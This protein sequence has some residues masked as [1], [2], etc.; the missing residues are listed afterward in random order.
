MH[1]CN[2]TEFL[3]AALEN[4]E[5]W[6]FLVG[7]HLEFEN[8]GECVIREVSLQDKLIVL[9]PVGN[10]HLTKKMRL[11]RFNNFYFRP[12]FVEESVYEKI[13][14]ALQDSKYSNVVNNNQAQ[15][16]DNSGS[17]YLHQDKT[18]PFEISSD[19]NFG[20][21]SYR[22]NTQSYEDEVNDQMYWENAAYEAPKVQAMDPIRHKE[23]IFEFSTLIGI[24]TLFHFTRLEN[25][26]TILK[27]GLISQEALKTFPPRIQPTFNDFHRIDKH[28]EANCLSVSFPN[29]T[30][31]YKLRCAQEDQVWAILT[32]RSSILWELDCAFCQEN[33]ASRTV[34][35]V[36]LSERKT[37]NSF[38]AMFTSYPGVS[39]DLI[40][41]PDNYPVHPQAEVLVFDRIDPGYI[42]A[43]YFHPKD[44][45][46]L[47]D[48]KTIPTKNIEVKF[49]DRYFKPRCDW[50]FWK[51]RNQ[52]LNQV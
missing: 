25:L 10:F 9:S 45:G 31:F 52:R 16:N 39:R 5:L 32:L 34:T 44:V 2:P 4:P 33:A 29:S 11:D 48:Y 6:L 46:S 19:K 20:T 28:P 18:V 12:F 26:E 43:V 37:F 42:K 49:D 13:L 40:G 15:K 30:W 21:G 50:E 41:I 7:I 17:K 36:S 35:S 27:Y 1:L 3:F 22:T 38:K 47:L 51:N 24:D 14:A 23:L 8:R